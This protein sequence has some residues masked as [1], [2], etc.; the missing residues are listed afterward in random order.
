MSVCE[1]RGPKRFTAHLLHILGALLSDEVMRNVSKVYLAH[2]RF[3]RFVRYG[4]LGWSALVQSVIASHD[5]SE[6]LAPKPTLVCSSSWVVTAIQVLGHER[7]NRKVWL[8]LFHVAH[9]AVVWIHFTIWQLLLSHSWVAP[10]VNRRHRLAV[11][12]A[13][14]IDFAGTIVLVGDLL[15]LIE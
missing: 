3:R 5:C 9:W 10:S 14:C 1:S 8:F 7:V 11:L 6:I 13:I 2:L 12:S 15:S 4:L